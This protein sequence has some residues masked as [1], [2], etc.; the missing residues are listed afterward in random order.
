MK[1]SEIAK[2]LDLKATTFFIATVIALTVNSLLNSLTRS[3]EMTTVAENI[4]ATVVVVLGIFSYVMIVRG[5]VA[6]DKACKLSEK[7]ENFYMGRN[8]T[9]FSVM[10]I[11]FSVILS[12]AAL[13]FSVFISQYNAAEGL[14]L[15]DI[16]ARNNILVI[17]ALINI[18]MQFF[19]ISTPFIFYLWKIYKVAPK[20]DSTNNF[21]LLTMIVLVVHL[22]IGILNSVYS[23]RGGENNFLPDFSSILNTIKFVVLLV[24]FM[25]RRKK[26]L[27]G[28]KEEEK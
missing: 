2:G 21:A 5:F 4:A 28:K 22:V 20:T 24:F 18:V 16:Q 27:S 14:T 25:T 12:I 7:N 10:C 8:L 19:S 17:T 3:F 1:K 13:V 9:V 6:V 26:L 23:V 15:S 11:I